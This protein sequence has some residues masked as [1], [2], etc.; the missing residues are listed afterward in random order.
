MS[1]NEAGSTVLDSL[2]E[3]SVPSGVLDGRTCLDSDIWMNRIIVGD[4]REVLKSISPDVVDLIHTSPPYN[5]EKQYADSNDNLAQSEYIELLNAVFTQCF[6]VMRPGA[7]LFLQTGYS[8]K[9][10]SEIIPIDIW[11]YQIMQEIGFRLWD[12]II[13]HYRGGP[14]LSR[15][16]KNTHESILWW[17]KPEIDGSIQPLFDVDSVREESRSYDK[18]NNL[19]GKNP[20]NVWS[21]DR[22]AYG[23]HARATSHIAIYPESVTERIIR[24][25]SKPQDLV[26]DPF[27]GSGTTPALAR[28]LGRRWIGVELSPTYAAEAEV[29]IGSKQ[30]S[31]LAS[32]LSNLIKLVCFGNK[33]GNLRLG[34]VQELMNLWLGQARA[35]MERYLCMEKEQLGMVFKES[36]NG[37]IQHKDA[38][39]TVWKYFDWFFESADLDRESLLLGSIALDTAYPQRRKWNS[40]RKF[41]HT[42]ELMQRLFESDGGLSTQTILKLVACEPSAYVVSRQGSSIEFLGPLLNVRSAKHNT[43]SKSEVLLNQ[44][45]HDDGG[46]SG[47]LGLETPEDD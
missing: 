11:S 7:S 40:V 41:S 19:F 21:E 30:P 12:R 6:R 25:C 13:W 1:F 44:N 16:F 14:S 36:A 20:G 17:V 2:C 32:L 34:Y 27:A 31:E 23:G 10:G 8:Q 42:L 35:D 26:L 22:V 43:T 18:R 3:S 37:P 39:P 46:F 5:I 15:K 4:S 38:K 33:N 28:S 47:T 29:R 9:T 45:R 24:S